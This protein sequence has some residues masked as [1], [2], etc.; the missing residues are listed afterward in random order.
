MIGLVLLRAL[1]AP[2]TGRNAALCASASPHVILDDEFA[3]LARTAI[4]GD[5]VLNL[6]NQHVELSAP[7]VMKG[8]T[9]L[10][11]AGGS[12]IGSGHAIFQVGG[13]RKG[14][15]ELCDVKLQH[16]SSPERLEKRSLG[17]ALFARGKSRMALRGCTI[18][19][20]A[21]FGLWVVQKAHVEADSCD[22]LESGRSSVV[23]FEDASV[24]L[25]NTLITDA[26]CHA[27]CARGDTRVVVR[28]SRIERA[29]L[30]A[31]YCCN[32]CGIRTDCLAGRS[33]S[34]S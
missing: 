34:I 28:R 20:E 9:T 2:A 31:I 4:E 23:C 12:I 29:E 16:M 33:P 11:I 10:R 32:E 14:L 24:E 17:A 8:A 27:V 26:N 22:F 18:S 15:L 13:S 19:S 21:G 25:D 6:A 3:D 1:R 7:F 30:R 5:S